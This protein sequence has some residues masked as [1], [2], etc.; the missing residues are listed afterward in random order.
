M[1]KKLSKLG[2][3]S[4]CAVTLALA[5]ICGNVSAE[6]QPLSVQGNKVLVGGTPVGLEGI[7]LFWSNTNWGAEKWY[8]AD[9]VK[10]IKTEFNANLVR[11]AIGHGAEGDIDKD[12]NGN[13]ARLDA[14]IQAAID[15]D[16]YVIVDYHSHIAHLNWES[17][18]DFFGAVARKWGNHPNVI[19]EIYNEPSC[20]TNNNCGTTNPFYTWDRDVR[21]YAQNISEFIRTI[22]PDNLIIV[23]TP[24]W[25]QD[26]DVASRN[27]INVPNLAYTIHFYANGHGQWLRDKAQIALNNGAALFATEWA[28]TEPSGDGPLDK[29][30]ANKWI[31]FLRANKISHAGWSFHDKNE[32]SS[33]FNGNGSLK[34]SGHY[35]K[36]VL[37]GRE[38]LPGEGD[39]CAQAPAASINSTIE[40]ESYCAMSGIQTENTSDAGGGKN[41]GWI[42]FGDWMSYKINVPAAGSYKVSY[43]VAAKT[44]TG[45]LQLE[46]AGGTPS[47]GTLQFAPTGDWQAWKTE[48]HVVTLPAGNQVFAIKALSEGWNLNWFKIEPVPSSSS[49]S[50]T[51]SANSLTHIATLQA[52]SY[53]FMSGVQ[54]ESTSD[55]GGGQNVGWI[56]AGDWLSYVNTPVT[57]PSAGTYELEFRV[58]SLNSGGSFNFEEAGGS[59]VYTSVNFNATGG[60]QNWTSVKVR[61]NLPAGQR[62]FG[63]KANNGGWNINWFKISKV[64]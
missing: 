3:V 19:Y 51:S 46:A 6:V 20:W 35:I 58:A 36:G 49:S 40:A 32:T 18:K 30:E 50:S 25:S 2:Q 31:E 29:N 28:A 8:T 52:E 57:I 27:K 42:D 11:A 4:T 22:D 16:M 17:A 15:N 23:G 64:N 21:P 1:Y 10:R 37:A 53:S 44:E 43:R 59:P 41:V 63:I 38:K 60:W 55:A 48:S 45:Y 14:V 54:T 24:K 7:S 5:G 9:T 34:E 56:D 39:N 47:F 12:R 26:V 33:F 13:M 61:V 62:K